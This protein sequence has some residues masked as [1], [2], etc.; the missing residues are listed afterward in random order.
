MRIY[1]ISKEFIEV[2]GTK[3]GMAR[4]VDFCGKFEDFRD[5][6]AGNAR[7]HDD[8]SIRDEIEIIFEIVEDL[9]GIF[10]FEVGLCDDKDNS[11]AGVDDLA[12]ETLVEFGVRLGA[13]DEHAA[14]VGFFD[15]S[16]ATKCTEFFDA[17]FAL[18]R[19]TE[20]GGIEKLNCA[21]L[22]A[23]F[24]AIDV[25]SSPREIGDNRLLLGGK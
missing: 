16:K 2:R 15:G 18:P 1:G 10:V 21:T 23:D 9:I 19:L 22:V 5:I 13:I 11:L 20:A 14:D 6:F 7:G 3:F 17:Y 8:W 12:G 4:F 25:A 24:S